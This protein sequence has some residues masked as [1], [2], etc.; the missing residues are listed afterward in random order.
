MMTYRDHLIK[1]LESDVEYFKKAYEY[2]A[3]KLREAEKQQNSRFLDRLA[4]AALIAACGLAVYLTFA[5]LADVGYWM[6]HG[7]R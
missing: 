7:W 6:Q 2:K 3:R 1:Q 4:T 5:A